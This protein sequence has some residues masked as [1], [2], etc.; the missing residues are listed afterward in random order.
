MSRKNEDHIPKDMADLERIFYGSNKDG[1]EVDLHRQRR[2]LDYLR[3]QVLS[4]GFEDDAKRMFAPLGKVEK[5]PE[6]QKHT[7][8]DY[9]IDDMKLLLE[10]TA[11]NIDE[12]FPRNL[13]GKDI[14]RKLKGAIDPIVTKDASPFLNYRKGGV[15]V[16]TI[17]FNFFSKFSKILDDKLSETSG[18]FKEDLDFLVFFPQPASINNRSSWDVFPTVFYVKDKSLAERFREAF[19]GQNYKIIT[20]T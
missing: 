8:F 1:K 2:Y 16:Y 9:K 19:H 17:V 11:L 20:V 6:T 12:T 3:T 15:I 13:T 18:L 7:N 5:I 10:V 4:P 14:S